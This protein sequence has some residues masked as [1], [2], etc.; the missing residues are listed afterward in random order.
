[1][2]HQA[3][4]DIGD[5]RILRWGGENTLKST[6]KWCGNL[7]PTTMAL[8][9]VCGLLRRPMPDTASWNSGTG[10]ASK[11]GTRRSWIKAFTQ[12]RFAIRLDL[13]M[14]QPSWTLDV[15][16]ISMVVIQILL[17]LR[18]ARKVGSL[19]RVDNGLLIV[20]RT[21]KRSLLVWVISWG[22]A[23]YFSMSTGVEGI[24]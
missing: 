2:V 3:K 15:V 6:T 10:W 1:M 13:P 17:A 9:Q 11:N 4:H 19:L 20:K 8:E 16:E 23:M 14:N 22:L 5:E 21:K 24:S 7:G 18:Q 12:C